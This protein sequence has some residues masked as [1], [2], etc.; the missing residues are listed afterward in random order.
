MIILSLCFFANAE[1]FLT[2][3]EDA[4]KIAEAN[5]L[6][7][8]LNLQRALEEV[9]HSK[10]NIGIFLPELDFSFMDSAY[11]HINKG[12]Y[13]QKSIEAGITQ[14]IF[15]GGKSAIEYKMNKEKSLYNFWEA[16]KNY[17]NKKNSIVKAYF[18]A[19]LSKLKVFVFEEAADNALEAINICEIQN[20]EGLISK[21]DY[22]ESQIRFRKILAKEKSAQNECA[23]YNRALRILMNL[24]KNE[25]IVFIEAF[26]P[27]K[28]EKEEFKSKDLKDSILKITDTALK[29]N[30]DLKKARAQSEWISKQRSLLK[31]AFF[32]SVSARAGISFSGRNYPLGS[33]EYS[34]KLILSFDDNPWFSITA[35]KNSDFEKDG[36]H[37]I[38]DAISGKAKYDASVISKLKI[39]KIDLEKSMIQT[40]KTKQAVESQIIQLIQ[41]IENLE[42]EA[43]INYESVKL[44]EK[45]VNLSKIQHEEGVI[46]KSAYLEDLNE[47][48]SEKINYLENKIKR[49]LA[50][51]EL[52][53]L[54]SVSFE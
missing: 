10:K 43:I 36:L 32:P 46:T 50:L 29:N 3:A 17:E 12:E 9:R 41:N 13:K 34:L 48:A 7:G 19:L 6:E 26:L 30:L 15:N 20:E 44:K 27:E 35:S 37:S 49:K 53:A 52:E 33:P 22:L 14:K 38:S 21:A 4:V 39:S 2:S 31:R 16:K 8:K 23:D 47:F 45:K 51:M 24:D 54:S 42:E 1:I 28:F 25:E 11:A 40:E 5:D 18:D